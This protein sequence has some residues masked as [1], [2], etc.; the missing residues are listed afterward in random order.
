MDGNGTVDGIIFED[1]KEGGSG[2]WGVD[3][4]SYSI[5]KVSST[6]DYFISE[7]NYK[8]PFGT[9]N[10]LS[11]KNSGN[12]RFYVMA[13]NDVNSNTYSY[14]DA[15]NLASNGWVVPNTNEWFAFGGKMS[16]TTSNYSSYGLKSAYW[17]SE[18]GPAG[19]V[20][21]YVDFKQAEIIGYY[22][23]TKYN[24]R[25]CKTF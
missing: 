9:R 25:L 3:N 14:A 1:F 2:T 22:V 6:K 24:V 4:G 12:D 15:Q 18:K 7:T 16:I 19:I 10:V 23:S 17:S 21:Y 13:L 11:P 8:G 20:A 5:T